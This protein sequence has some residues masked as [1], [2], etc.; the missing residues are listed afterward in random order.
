MVLWNI[1]PCWAQR[2]TADFDAPRKS[3]NRE[4]VLVSEPLEVSTEAELMGFGGKS[5]LGYGFANFEIKD[6]CPNQSYLI[7]GKL[8][9]KAPHVISFDSVKKSCGCAR[10]IL[11]S[12]GKLGT[13]ETLEFTILLRAPSSTESGMSS[14]T[15]A[16]MNEDEQVANL[17]FHLSLAGNLFVEKRHHLVVSDREAVTKL[18]PISISKPVEA[19]QINVHV[20]ES[21]SKGL[22]SQ[23]VEINGSC[24]LKLEIN[25]E[26]LSSDLTAGEIE[27]VDPLARRAASTSL[28]LKKRGVISISPRSLHLRS[29]ENDGQ[30]HVSFIVE[31]DRTVL[32]SDPKADHTKRI[33]FELPNAN[34]NCEADVKRIA[35]HIYRVELKVEPEDVEGEVSGLRPAGKKRVSR[36]QQEETQLLISILGANS[37]FVELFPVTGIHY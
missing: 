33:A 18:I 29:A 36:D 3:G 37:R 34:A 13:L 19:K 32:P 10:K 2:E 15:V 30:Q 8:L 6:L 12:S 7:T 20:Q 23:I 4:S 24:F 22:T 1:P 11:P 14:F 26:E 27:L 17:I 25:P 5:T 16:L 35:A 28:L 21:I 31:I 9:N